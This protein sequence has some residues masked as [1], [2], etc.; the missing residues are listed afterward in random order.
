MEEFYYQNTFKV[1]TENKN[2]KKKNFMTQKS[3]VSSDERSEASYNFA[4]NKT[5]VSNFMNSSKASNS[6][7]DFKIK[8]SAQKAKVT[9]KGSQINVSTKTDN[10]SRN[11]FISESDITNKGSV[12][13]EVEDE[14]PTVEKRIGQET[15]KMEAT[16]FGDSKDDSLKLSNQEPLVVSSKSKVYVKKAALK[17]LQKSSAHDSGYMDETPQSL[18]DSLQYIIEKTEIMEDKLSRQ[19]GNMQ[20]Y[21]KKINDKFKNTD[22]ILKDILNSQSMINGAESG[23]N[24]KFETLLNDTILECGPDG[25]VRFE[26]LIDVPSNYD[27][28]DLEDDNQDN[29]SS[30]QKVDLNTLG[31]DGRISDDSNL[32]PHLGKVNSKGDTFEISNNSNDHKPLILEELLP[33]V[34]LANTASQ[35]GCPRERRHAKG[36]RNH[37]RN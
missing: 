20:F 16:M 32:I 27:I 5:K 2:T 22:F 18:F 29:N 14:R 25:K 21:V 35:N 3:N 8:S 34:P 1:G 4:K 31:G 30:V 24:S 19:Q 10:K 15:P 36:R 12:I 11:P 6:N 37:G 26:D 23:E 28:E 13:Q 9:K 17:E 33:Q 7:A